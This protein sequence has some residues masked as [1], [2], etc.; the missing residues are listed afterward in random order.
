MGTNG[1]K[2]PGA[3]RK[4][5][6]VASHTLQASQAKAEL[7]RAYVENIKP[8]NEAL[9]KKATG[10]DIQAIK[11]IHDRVY[12]KAPQA[13]TGADGGPLV[14]SLEAREKSKEA[15]SQFLGHE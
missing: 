2:R 4:K 11:E 5:G 15:I 10:G 7:I 13:I 6:S 3:G 8:I 9:I 14:V 12:G 1:G